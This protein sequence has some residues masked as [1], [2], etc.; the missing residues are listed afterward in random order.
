MVR[1]DVSNCPRCAT[2]ASGLRIRHRIT[3]DLDGNVR[4]MGSFLGCECGA[5]TRNG[6]GV[7]NLR[8]DVAEEFGVTRK[9]PESVMARV[10]PRVRR[11]A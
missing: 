9:T 8:N 5:L 6:A 1:P 11:A 7:L 4:V 2:P 3:E 10:Q